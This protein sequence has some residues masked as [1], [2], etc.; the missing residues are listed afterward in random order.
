ME[1]PDPPVGRRL[2]SWKEIASHLG[3]SVRTVQRWEREQGLRVHRLPHNKQSSVY[4]Y[5]HELDEWWAERRNFLET[6]EDAGTQAPR[7]DAPKRPSAVAPLD[8][9]TREESNVIDGTKPTLVAASVPRRKLVLAAVTLAAVAVLTGAFVTW[10]SLSRL[11]SE[12]EERE[13]RASLLVSRGRLLLNQRTP[14]GFEEALKAFHQAT[15]LAPSD[16]LAYAGLADTYSL[17]QAFGLMPKEQALPRARAAAY[18]AVTFGA[19]LAAP[20]TSLSMVLWELGE[21]AEAISEAERALAADPKYATA[22]HWY[23]LFLHATGRNDEAIEHAQVALALDPLSPIIGCDLSDIFRSAGRIREARTLLEDLSRAHPTFP[24][25]HIELSE[26]HEQEGRYDLARRQVETAIGNGDDR[27]LILAHL[28][29]LAAQD[30]DVPFARAIARRLEAM[31]STGRLVPGEALAKAWLASGDISTALSV[32]ERDLAAR[33]PWVLQ[34]STDPQ[35]EALRRDRRW[36]DV[37]RRLKRFERV[38]TGV[39]AS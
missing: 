39:P 6:Q 33:L 5:A 20:R 19:G 2:G 25:V 1:I 31:D 16:P 28:A 21:R 8:S 35:Y 13:Q 17:M 14:S 24:Q 26:I 4:A 18:Q 30:G 37:S 10:F 9:S 3:R 15:I 27:P 23:A 7:G 12:E 22:Q 29:W 11:S 36:P 32:V 38:V 34:A